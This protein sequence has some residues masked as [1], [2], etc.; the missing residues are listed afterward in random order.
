MQSQENK[1][2]KTTEE[3]N[4]NVPKK[5]HQIFFIL[6]LCLNNLSVRK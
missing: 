4:K 1:K 5:D 3:I 6:A 2:I